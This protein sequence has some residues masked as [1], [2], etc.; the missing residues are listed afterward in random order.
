MTSVLL[1]SKIVASL[2]KL[3]GNKIFSSHSPQMN[4]KYTSKFNNMDI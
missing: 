3:T 4:V 2:K 1:C